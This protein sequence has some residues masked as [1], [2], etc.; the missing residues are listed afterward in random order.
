[1]SA[2]PQKKYTE[3]EYLAFERASETKHEFYRGEILAMAGAIEVASASTEKYDCTTKFDHYATLNSLQEYVLIEQDRPRVERYTRQT[4]G[5]WGQA[6]AHGLD[7]TLEL[8]S[9]GCT[10]ALA[11]VYARVEFEETES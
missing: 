3:A 7:Q 1:M 11:E 5:L 10:L 6:V 2:L 9:I 8:P 4:D